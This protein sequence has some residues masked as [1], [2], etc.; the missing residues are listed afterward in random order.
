MEELDRLGPS[1]SIVAVAAVEFLG[2]LAALVPPGLLFAASIQAH[3]LFPT[4]RFESLD[5]AV[6]AVYV[7]C[8][9]CLGL[10]G[11]V[12]AV[13]L[14]RL[15]EWA[16]RITLVLATVPVSGCTL[17]IILRPLPVFPPD[18]SQGAILA[19]GGGLYFMFF[20]LLLAIL[21]PVSAWWWILLTRESV[22]RQFR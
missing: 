1:G 13:G 17:L 6:Y 15:R 22:R 20:K 16:R 2:S 10:L 7:A 3:R 18:P 19:I 4:L 21:I 8:P 14:L 5:T 12:T 11:I 9:L